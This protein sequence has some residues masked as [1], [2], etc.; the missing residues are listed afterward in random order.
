MKIQPHG[1]LLTIL[2]PGECYD[3]L[4][5]S[6]MWRWNRSKK[7]LEAEMTTAAI[8]ALV[9][10]AGKTND[11]LSRLRQRAAQTEQ[12][13]QEQRDHMSGGAEPILEPL[14]QDANLM[15]H[16]VVAYNLALIRFGF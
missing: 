10:A 15:N 16:Q 6:G 11:A 13:M 12:R 8:D 5:D 3:A 4:I 2:E 1:N 9:S 14:I 7:W